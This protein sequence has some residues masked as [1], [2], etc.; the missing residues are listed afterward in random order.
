VDIT[1]A[2]LKSK[3]FI[4]LF[5]SIFLVIALGFAFTSRGKSWDIPTDMASVSA[6][7]QA[8]EV[9]I[10]VMCT[11]FK[12]GLL[13]TGLVM[14]LHA[15]LPRDDSDYELFSTSTE[16]DG[17]FVSINE[18]RQLILYFGKAS[19][20]YEITMP[21][22]EF[23]SDVA[24]RRIDKNGN[25]VIDQL[26]TT[27]FLTRLGFSNENI[28]IEAFTSSPFLSTVVKVVPL[29]LLSNTRCSGKGNLGLGI[30]NSTAAI[31]VGQTGKT[32]KASM[33]RPIFVQ[34]SLASLFV[35]LWLVGL[36]LTRKREVAEQ[37]D[38]A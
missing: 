32:S 25:V 6:E 5:R 7:S 24:H 22:P 34:R 14:G 12:D 36:W 2:E 31:D 29:A 37:A 13:K 19:A 35:V 23:I 10:E 33:L 15:S 17:L 20:G 9:D 30:D 16:A 18:Q 38:H 8:E 28:A 26:N 3:L 11:A 4:Q 1:N 27:L 21:D